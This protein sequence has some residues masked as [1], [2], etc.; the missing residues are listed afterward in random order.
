M[1]DRRRNKRIRM[2]EF[3]KIVGRQSI[4]IDCIVRNLSAG[5]AC[6]QVE[7]TEDLPEEFLL[8]ILVENLRRVCRIAWRSQDRMGVVFCET[9]ARTSVSI[10]ASN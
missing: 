6:L 7:S 5:G 1:I 2:L 8:K 3:G 9:R 4:S 10:K